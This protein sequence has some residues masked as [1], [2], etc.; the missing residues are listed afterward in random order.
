MAPW[1]EPQGNSLTHRAEPFTTPQLWPLQMREMK[2]RLHT[3]LKMCSGDMEEELA[4]YAGNVARK[5]S[6]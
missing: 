4:H 1:I 2:T 5:N 6:N 3:H